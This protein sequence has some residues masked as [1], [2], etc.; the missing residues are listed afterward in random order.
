MNFTYIYED[1]RRLILQATQDKEICSVSWNISDMKSAIPVGRNAEFK[2][3][4]QSSNFFLALSEL[5][6]SNVRHVSI[7]REV[8]EFRGACDRFQV[9]PSVPARSHALYD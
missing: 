7:V 6:S 9:L 3:T 2:M 5:V 1:I 8:Y 4:L